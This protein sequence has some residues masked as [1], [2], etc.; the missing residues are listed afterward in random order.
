[1]GVRSTPNRAGPTQDG[2]QGSAVT[3]QISSLRKCIGQ[4]R[5]LDM[6]RQV[7]CKSVLQQAEF[8]S[9]TLRCFPYP[10]LASLQE[11]L[12]S[13]I[14]GLRSLRA[15]AWAQWC[16]HSWHHCKKKVY[17]YIKQVGSQAS[18]SQLH[19]GC[20]EGPV[21]LSVRLRVAETSG[22]LFWKQGIPFSVQHGA[23]LPPNHGRGPSGGC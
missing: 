1:M 19:H 10:T 11:E 7:G 23:A 6:Y 14:S 21:S 2:T 20:L 22:N 15:S 16:E 13:A 9:L 5:R 3:A 4:R 17:R 8:D 18:L 12:Q